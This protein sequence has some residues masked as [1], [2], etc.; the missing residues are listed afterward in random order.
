MEGLRSL[1]NDKNKEFIIDT[2]ISAQFGTGLHNEAI[3]L[4]A[5]FTDSPI[6]LPR[7]TGLL[8]EKIRYSDF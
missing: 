7:G 6:R 4:T 2:A 1:S 3:R 5:K 8:C